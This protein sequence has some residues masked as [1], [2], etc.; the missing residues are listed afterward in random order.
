M[1][2]QKNKC[3]EVVIEDDVWIGANVVVSPGV[4]IKR[5][6]IVGAN[7]VVTKDV[8][9]YSIVGGAPAKFIKYRFDQET[10]KKASKVDL[11][12]FKIK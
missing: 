6:A 9:A 10:I 8:D 1:T 11:S 12:K 2:L 7:S 3:K 5:G 4:H